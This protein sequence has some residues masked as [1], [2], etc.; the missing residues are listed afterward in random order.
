M[1]LL[2]PRVADSLKRAI[3]RAGLS[4]LARTLLELRPAARATRRADKAQLRA[5][6]GKLSAI[7]A[8]IAAA[9]ARA[10]SAALVTGMGTVPFIVHQLPVLAGMTLAGFSPVILLPSRANRSQRRIYEACGVTRF[11]YWEDEEDN[12]DARAILE[13]LGKCKTQDDVLDLTWQGISVGKYAVSTLMRRLRQGHIDI[14]DPNVRGHM[15]VAL[16]RTLDHAAAARAMIARFD[17]KLGVFVDRGYT[18]EG[19][20]FDACIS[21]GVRPITINTAHRDNT[22]MLKCYG[23][24]NA[25]VHPSS[26]SLKSWRRLRKMKWTEHCWQRLQS[27]LDFCYGSGQ[28]YG[29][30]G[31]QFNTK[32]IA[33]AELVEQL[34]IDPGKKTVLLFPHIFWDATFFWGDDVFRDYADWFRESVRAAWRNDRVNWIIKVHPANL[35][36]N[37]RDGINT[38]FSELEVLAE[39]GQLP[40]HIHVL[41]PTTDISTRSLFEIGDVC[42]TVRGTVGIEA[43]IAGLSVLTAGTGRYDRLGFTEDIKTPGAWRERLAHI[44]ETEPPTAEQIELARRYAHGVFLN[45]PLPVSCISFRFEQVE[46]APIAIEVRAEAE[47]AVMNC[48]DVKAISDWLATGE[49]DLFVRQPDAA[50][51]PR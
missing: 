39:F 34:G 15:A 26:L 23:P 28:W 49:E 35:I 27:E 45:R 4:S 51:Q 37:Q 31:T 40:P 21:T 25:S 18:P 33:K 12:G 11:A 32:S 20:M 48:S 22:L 43:A 42:L 46:G 6:S 10:S 50:T 29:E 9:D 17:A 5:L 38:P 30:V 8:Q 3:N 7:R 36:K 41:S 47:R 13:A 16:R 2:D 44:E 14:A 24:D 1:A 19:P